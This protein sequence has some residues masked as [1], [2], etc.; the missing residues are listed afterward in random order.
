YRSPEYIAALFS[1]DHAIAG[2]LHHAAVIERVVFMQYIGT[3]DDVLHKSQ[4]PRLHLDN[5]FEHDLIDHQALLSRRAVCSWTFHSCGSE[6]TQEGIALAGVRQLDWLAL[7]HFSSR[8]GFYGHS[9]SA[10][11]LRRSFGLSSRSLLRRNLC[12]HRHRLLR[13]LGLGRNS[14]LWCRIG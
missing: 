12:L 4:V 1:E 14:W 2:N 10:R 13:I 11:R 7:R 3:S 9:G 8:F 5:A 6:R